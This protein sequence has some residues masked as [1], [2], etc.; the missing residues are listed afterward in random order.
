MYGADAL[1]GVVNFITKKTISYF[2]EYEAR[3]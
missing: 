2:F 1:G 3:Q